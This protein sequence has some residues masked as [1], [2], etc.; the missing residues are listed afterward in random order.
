MKKKKYNTFKVIFLILMFIYLVIFFSSY[1]GYYEYNNYKKTRLT[2]EQIKKFENDVKEGKELDLEEYLVIN[3]YSYK[4]KL[5]SLTIRISEG[6]SSVVTYG[7]K[8][9]FKYISN[10]IDE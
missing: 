8:C 5:S 10:F 2:N 1:T 9:T 4:T 3:K 7:V 6:I